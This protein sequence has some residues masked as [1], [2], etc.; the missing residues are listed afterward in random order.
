MHSGILIRTMCSIRMQPLGL[1]NS[2][3]LYKWQEILNPFGGICLY[4]Q[5]FEPPATHLKDTQTKRLSPKH[6]FVIAL[7]SPG[8]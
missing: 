6:G 5:G 2:R 4:L 7:S 3:N 1:L 8:Q